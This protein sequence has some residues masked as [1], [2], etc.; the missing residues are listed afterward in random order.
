MPNSLADKVII[1]TG[2]GSGIGRSAALLMARRGAR[3]MIADIDVQAAE[4]TAADIK[5]AGGESSFVRTERSR[6]SAGWT[7]LSTTPGS[8]KTA[9]P[10]S[11]VTP[12]TSGTGS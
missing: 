2:G 12:W 3:V 4:H 11:P 9:A 7:A 5:S 10:M 6:R 1:V 8:W